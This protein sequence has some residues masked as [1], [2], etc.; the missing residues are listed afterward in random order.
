MRT[1]GALGSVVLIGLVVGL[2]TQ[3]GMFG[4]VAAQ[5]ASAP[6][7]QVTAADAP[8]V[9]ADPQ[10]VATTVPVATAQMVAAQAEPAVALEPQ[11]VT[12]GTDDPAAVADVVQPATDVAAEPAPAASGARHVILIVMENKEHEEISSSVHAPYFNALA[13]QYA[14]AD[15]YHAIRAPSLPNYLALMSGHT[16]GVS[17]DCTDCFQDAPSLPDQLETAG[18]TWGGY[19]EDM[20]SP[21]FLEASSGGYAMKHNPFAYFLA[22]RNDP[23]R[24]ARIMPLT[25]LSTDLAANTLPDFSLI[26]PNLCHSGHDCDT[27]TGD[28]WLASVV[29]TILAAPAWKDGG[30]LAITWDEG[31]SGHTC[32]GGTAWGGRVALL[33]ASPTGPSGYHS[34]TPYSHYSLLRSIEDVWS[35]PHLGHADEAVTLPLTDLLPPPPGAATYCGPGQR[36]ELLFGFGLLKGYLGDRMGTPVECEHAEGGSGD[37]VQ[38]TT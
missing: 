31:Y 3:A 8:R 36:P 38:L 23:Q 27:K 25:Q 34:S 4:N 28:E 16:F 37:T 19:F 7:Q 11:A 15:E 5:P 6:T 2:V 35:L 26:V 14:Q 24:C 1:M 30:T 12:A 10:V 17:T 22:I 32:C 21:C 18:K 20:P 33:V 29:P 9:S 13:A